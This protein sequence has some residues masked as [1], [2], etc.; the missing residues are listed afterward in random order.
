MKNFEADNLLEEEAVK[1]TNKA[2]SNVLK[3][4]EK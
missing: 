4:K 2:F 1:N 3:I